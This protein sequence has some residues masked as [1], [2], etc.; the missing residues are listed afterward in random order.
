MTDLTK[1]VIFELEEP[2]NQERLTLMKPKYTKKDYE[3]I[4]KIGVGQILDMATVAP[5]KKEFKED[6]IS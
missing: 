2:E 3:Q 1:S 5:K 4:P 6:S